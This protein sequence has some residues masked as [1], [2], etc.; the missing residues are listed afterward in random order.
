MPGGRRGRWV[1]ALGIGAGLLLPSLGCQIAAYRGEA[2]PAASPTTSA[3]AAPASRGPATALPLTP[4]REPTPTLQ[5]LATSVPPAPPRLPTT[6]PTLTPRP[7]ASP[8]LGT[9]SP[10]GS[11][12]HFATTPGP[13]SAATRAPG[14][15]TLPLRGELRR[16]AASAR[17]LLV[18]IDGQGEQEIGLT[19]NAALRRAD[20]R[21]TQLGELRPGD[22]LELLVH[23]T[24]TG[25]LVAEAVTVLASAPR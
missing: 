18:A 6:S 23:R 24:N 21:P 16:V 7:T 9:P 22:R 11:I 5:V 20:G 3:V 4:P 10:T 14:G 15:A 13:S 25:A 8:P 19:P 2:R 12:P 17:V 1:W